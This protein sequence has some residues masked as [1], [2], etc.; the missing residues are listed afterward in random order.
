M[1]HQ[2]YIISENSMPVLNLRQITTI[3]FWKYVFCYLL[4]VIIIMNLKGKVL[5]RLEKK[6]YCI[7]LTV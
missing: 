2:C 3:S 5:T 7:T 4:N 1:Y 6:L